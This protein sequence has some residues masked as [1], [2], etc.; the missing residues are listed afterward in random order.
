MTPHRP[1]A[2]PAASNDWKPHRSRFPIVGTRRLAAAALFALAAA[3]G[4]RAQEAAALKPEEIKEILKQAD[5]S[6]GNLGGVKWDVDIDAFENGK[7]H[8]NSLQVSA[9]GYDFLA[10]FTEPAKAKGQRVLFV[11]RNMWYTKPGVKKPVPISSRQKLVGGA[12]YGDIAAT[13]F[14][15]DYDATPLADETIDGVACHVFDMKAATKKTTYDRVKYWVSKERRVAVKAEY[16]A[17][18]GKMFKTARFAFD[19]AVQVDGRDLPFISKIVI[20]DALV[21][22]NVTTMAFNAPKIEKIPDSTFDVNL[23][24]G[25]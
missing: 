7:Q 6:R 23:L 10:I 8:N 3:G 2:A 25:R 20:T 22:E 14:A 11:E 21:K 17:V 1:T 18:S 9:R 16:Y 5:A 19:K 4:V 15:E 13:N 24:M 12:A